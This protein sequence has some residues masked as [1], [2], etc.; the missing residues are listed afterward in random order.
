[1]HN[2][3]QKI[4][5]LFTPG[6]QRRTVLMLMLVILMALAETV[7]VI[8]IM[9]FLTVLART[10]VIHENAWLSKIYQHFSFTSTNAFIIALGFTSMALVIAS[11]LFKAVTLHTINRFIYMLRHSL[12]ARLL[13]RYLHQPYEFFLMRNPAELS[14]NVLS[15]ADQLTFSL[16]QPLAQLI[17]HGTVML[18]MV[19]LI[20][21][22]DP[23]MAAGI[24]VAVGLLYGT[25]YLL[26][27][28]RL[29]RT[30]NARQEAD[31]GRYKSCSEALASIK[32]VKVTH[33]ADA[34]LSTYSRHSREFSR[35]MASVETITASPLYIV[36]AA[37]YTG[38]III[39]LILLQQ[40]NDVA[41]VLP[42]LGMYGF[43]AYRLLPAAQIM[44]RGFAK[45]QYSNATLDIIHNDIKLT[46]EPTQ[47]SSEMLRPQHEIRLSGIFY[48][49]P[50]TPQKPVLYDFDLKIPANTSLGI[51]GAS[52]SGK[53]T[54][55]DILL[56]LLQPQA[57]ML[58][59]DGQRIDVSNVHSWQ[60]AIGYVPQNIYLSDTSV[61]ANIA[62]GVPPDDID[63]QAVKRAARSAQIHDFVVDELPQGYSTL[64][65]D[66]GI[67]LSGGQRQRIGIARALYRD[68]PVLLM[69]E[70]TSALDSKTEEAVNETVRT[71]S[72]SRTIIVI[73]H[74]ET[75]L[76]AC[77]GIFRIINETG[78]RNPKF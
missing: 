61:A 60:R 63:M 70:A 34:W 54:L 41:H 56:G 65:G 45:L 2:T 50:S 28:G 71:L 36:E 10:D 69:D 14:K 66:R 78:S 8:S 25:I 7:G 24:V 13:S 18:A 23:W 20:V 22:Y 35:H 29:R 75:S 17:A 76:R 15:E 72:S 48:A 21:A 46:D 42:A 74:R 68:P 44:Y 73:A 11:S 1:M 19:A 16:L 31:V 9:P 26:V 58:S 12:S 59:V 37:G 39:A 32:D 51:A 30:G 43:A 49:Y 47:Q 40:S 55:M 57:G 53:S 64:V 4:W 77:T 3:L 33:T 38:L 27:R 5:T 52:G 67:R 6:E 62:F